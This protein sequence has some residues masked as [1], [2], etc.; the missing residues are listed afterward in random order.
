MHGESERVETAARCTRVH[1]PSSPPRAARSLGLLGEGQRGGEAVDGGD[2]LAYARRDG[3]DFADD[4]LAARRRLRVLPLERL[5]GRRRWWGTGAGWGACGLSRGMWLVEG[6]P[7]RV[8]N[9]WLARASPRVLSGSPLVRL[10]AVVRVWPEHCLRRCGCVPRALSGSAVVRVCVQSV[11]C[12]FAPRAPPSRGR[13]SPPPRA[14][15]RPAPEA[16]RV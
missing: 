7:G 6:R 3:H 1:M 2:G 15:T 5:G 8:V 13:A 11:C 16:R 4:C 14:A 9:R 12:A 10:S